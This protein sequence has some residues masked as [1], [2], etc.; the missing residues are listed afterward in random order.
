MRASLGR[1]LAIAYRH[2]CLYKRSP[3]RLMEVFYWPLLDLLVWGFLTLYLVQA[4]AVLPAVAFLLGA[5]ILWD[6]LFR[7]QQGISIAFL[8]EVWSRNLLN[9]FV[10]PLRAGEFLLA[11]ILISIGKVLAAATVTALLAWVF[12]SFNLF[13]MGL[14][15]IPFVLSLVATGWAIGI[16]T[17]AMVL[18][19]GQKAEVTAWALAFLIQPIA[20]VFYPVSVLPVWLQPLA[21]LIPATH[22]FEGM[23]A[24]I[25]TGAFPG[26]LLVYAAVL[27]VLHLGLALAFFYRMLRVVRDQG[28][29]VRI[30]E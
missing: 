8:E 15:L 28:L 10:T 16:L 17:T 27:N 24:V 12:Y 9:L 6:I 21:N 30:G 13:V 7:S 22:V 19:Y 29:L 14:A 11:T 18:R 20:A 1:I 4:R 3:A 23:R 26:R 5:M 25:L 2:L